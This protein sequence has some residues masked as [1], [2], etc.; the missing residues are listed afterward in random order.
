MRFVRY[1]LSQSPDLNSILSDTF[2]SIARGITA[3][4]E[5][6]YQIKHF[7]SFLLIC[8]PSVRL[9]GEEKKPQ[10]ILTNLFDNE[11]NLISQ[12]CSG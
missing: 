11:F 8:P 3:V 10:N 4:P 1:N 2:K 12:P 5:A 6:Q 7:M 9:Y